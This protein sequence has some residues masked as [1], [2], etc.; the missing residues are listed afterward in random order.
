MY[1][2][3]KGSENAAPPK[4]WHDESSTLLSFGAEIQWRTLKSSPFELRSSDFY[5]ENMFGVVRQFSS[6]WRANRW[7]PTKIDRLASFLK[8]EVLIKLLFGQFLSDFNDSHVI[9]TRIVSRLRTYFQ[10]KNRTIVAWTATILVCVIEF[11]RQNWAGW[12]THHVIFSGGPHSHC[13]WYDGTSKSTLKAAM[14]YM[15]YT[16]WTA[17]EKSKMQ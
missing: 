7:N 12:M 16:K 4:K 11:P 17:W 1:R 14:S 3:I 13:L 10:N 15:T 8:C 6:K 2:H 9:L 5:F